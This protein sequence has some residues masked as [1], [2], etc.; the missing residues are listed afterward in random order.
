MLLLRRLLRLQ[1]TVTSRTVSPET[2]VNQLLLQG[3]RCLKTRECL[4]MSYLLGSLAVVAVVA[5]AST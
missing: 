5:V 3:L 2:C 4:K 1:D